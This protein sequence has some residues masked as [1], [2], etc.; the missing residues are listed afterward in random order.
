MKTVFAALTLAT[1]ANCVALK[2]RE[3][4]TNDFSSSLASEESWTQFK[5]DSSHHRDSADKMRAE[6]ERLVGIYFDKAQA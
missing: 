1:V 4:P 5:K 3:G 6:R 2:V